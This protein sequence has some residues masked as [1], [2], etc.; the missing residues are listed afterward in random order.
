MVV[1]FT[2]D[3]HCGIEQGFGYAGL[4]EIR[5]NLEAKG[6]HVVPVDN[7]DAIQGEPI[8]TMING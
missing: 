8:G 1:L 7:G 3:V 5:E 4:A 6:D 2:G